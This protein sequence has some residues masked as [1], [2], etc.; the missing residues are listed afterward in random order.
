[1]AEDQ[2][3]ITAREFDGFKETI[4]QAI[5]DSS[6]NLHKR[7]D[8]IDRRFDS[9]QHTTNELLK[10]SGQ[11]SAKLGEHERRLNG[12][13]HRHARKEDPP[14]DN[15]PITVKDIKRLGFIIGG[16]VSAVGVLIKAVPYIVK[17]FQP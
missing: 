6:I 15:D 1:M 10:I 13:G 2:Q 5:A 3:H 16:I 8:G 17:A 11:H 9:L 4:V 14:S 7:L 12:N